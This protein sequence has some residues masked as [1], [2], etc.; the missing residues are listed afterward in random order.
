MKNRDMYK[1]VATKA[2]KEGKKKENMIRFKKR[3]EKLFRICTGMALFSI[4]L[5]LIPIYYQSKD[6]FIICKYLLLI[7]LAIMIILC[8]L[9]T[10][11]MYL[12]GID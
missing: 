7:P 4:I 3:S 12:V 8:I 1:T 5:L 6:I 9:Y 11:G 2:M 10:S